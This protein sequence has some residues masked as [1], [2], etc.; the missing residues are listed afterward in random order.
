MVLYIRDMEVD[1]SRLVKS[2]LLFADLVE[3][4]TNLEHISV[5]EQY[6]DMVINSYILWLNNNIINNNSDTN[7]DDDGISSHWQI[8]KDNV[9]SH[10]L[11]SLYMQDTKFM[12]LTV[13]YLLMYNR[14][15]QCK[16]LVGQ[17]SYD[18]KNLIYEQVP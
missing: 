18:I 11:F 16:L 2:S 15:E 14:W 8:N 5:P 4:Y 10:F 7:N 12:V 17:L 1:G 13:N 3:M 6:S 9:V